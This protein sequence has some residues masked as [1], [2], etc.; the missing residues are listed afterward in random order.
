MKRKEGLP[1]PAARTQRAVLALF[2]VIFFS[3]S[4]GYLLLTWNTGHP[5]TFIA[6]VYHVVILACYGT[7]W[8]LIA[9]LFRSQRATPAK[10]FWPGPVQKS[11]AGISRCPFGP[12]TMQV[13]RSSRRV[14]RLAVI[15]E[16]DTS[17]FDAS[18]SRTI[19]KRET[20]NWSIAQPMP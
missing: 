1:R 7:L 2:F 17:M 16:L 20:L 4:V 18:A 19:L 13:P 8:L 15:E 3:L 5:S 11:S 12:A 9:N 6:V 10:A 14:E